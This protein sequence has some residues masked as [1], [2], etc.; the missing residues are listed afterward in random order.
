M[1]PEYLTQSEDKSRSRGRIGQSRHGAAALANHCSR[2]NATMS[3]SLLLRHHSFT[4]QKC[5]AVMLCHPSWKGGCSFS[6]QQA[7]LVQCQSCSP[8]FLR[9]SEGNL[10][11]SFLSDSVSDMHPSPNSALVDSPTRRCQCFT[12]G[13]GRLKL[14]SCKTFGG[15]RV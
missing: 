2:V 6:T 5:N 7:A 12:M 10:H 9:L 8:M 11:S 13:V 3:H 14:T 1:G 4:H 15:L